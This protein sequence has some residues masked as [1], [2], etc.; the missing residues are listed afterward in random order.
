MA[1][2]SYFWIG[3]GA[4]GMAAGLMLI[5]AA[6]RTGEASAGGRRALDTPKLMLGVFLDLIGSLA[7]VYGVFLAR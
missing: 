1:M 7:L 4:L 2:A 6:V 3:G 5:L